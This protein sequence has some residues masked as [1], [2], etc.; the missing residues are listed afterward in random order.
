MNGISP[1]RLLGVR[2]LLSKAQSNTQR[3]AEKTR[4]PPCYRRDRP[5]AH[6]GTRGPSGVNIAVFGAHERAEDVRESPGT[7]GD[8]GG[9]ALVDGGLH[10]FMLA[11]LARTSPTCTRNLTRM[12][13]ARNP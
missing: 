2:R 13:R 9:D 6:P 8:S 7:P 12:P 4:G 10:G 11:R 5:Q 1:Q 3:A